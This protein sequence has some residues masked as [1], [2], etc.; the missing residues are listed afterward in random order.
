MTRIG[1]V[2]GK[3]L[4]KNFGNGNVI[5]K[6]GFSIFNFLQFMFLPYFSIFKVELLNRLNYFSFNNNGNQDACS[7]GKIYPLLRS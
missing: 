3:F 7:V 4:T 5:D 1:K 6:I 2:Y